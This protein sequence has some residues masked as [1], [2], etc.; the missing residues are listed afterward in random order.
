VAFAFLL[1]AAS[2]IGLLIYVIMAEATVIVMAE[3]EP[4]KVNL[5]ADVAD[6]PGGSA[7]TG[8]V[9]SVEGQIT[10]TFPVSSVVPVEGFAE[11]T[12]RITSRLDW[13]Q[14]F[15]AT[16]RLINP[17][18]VLFRLADSVT[19]PPHGSLVAPVK[20]D[21]P[22]AVGDTGH[23]TFVVPG[24]REATQALFVVETVEPP[25]GGLTY[26]GSLT[27]ADI[28]QALE[29]LAERLSAE[30]AADLREEARAQERGLT[31]EIV[32]FAV[33][34]YSTDTELGAEAEE[35]ALTL[36]G[37]TSAVLYDE[38]Q[39]VQAVRA[40]LVDG[41]P[42][43]QELRSLDEANMQVRLERVDLI[44]RQATVR[45]VT[46]AAAAITGAA[47]SLSPERLVGIKTDAAEKYLESVAGVSS[48]SINVRPV[49]SGRMPNVVEHIKVEVR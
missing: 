16:T 19:V 31:G 46:E 8:S 24:L 42:A 33:L 29:A 15:V 13:P 20:A 6:T 9:L 4:I 35:F 27:Q 44:G 32:D 18:G 14:T 48:A 25:S 28:D 22:G 40:K 11:T 43:E 10:Q 21:L 5:V 41:L 23:T 39:L 36:K 1:A 3:H 47:E 37:R 2:T 26:V 30:Q 12:V 17:D 49:W 7:V 34:A 38:A 45:V